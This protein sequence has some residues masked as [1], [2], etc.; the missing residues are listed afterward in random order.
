ML[1]ECPRVLS[2]GGELEWKRKVRL[3][4][5]WDDYLVEFLKLPSNLSYWWLNSGFP[6]GKNFIFWFILMFYK[7]HTRRNLGWCKILGFGVLVCPMFVR[8]IVV[9]WKWSRGG[10]IFSIE[11]LIGTKFRKGK[12]S[13]DLLNSITIV[14]TTWAHVCQ[15]LAMGHFSTKIAMNV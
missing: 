10:K 1:R 14:L 9:T 11:V 15:V 7:P 3:W 6:E 13:F 2:I 8:I 4:V 5:F 12:R